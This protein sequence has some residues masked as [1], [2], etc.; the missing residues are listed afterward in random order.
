MG[1]IECVGERLANI[2]INLPR[3]ARQPRLKRIDTLTYAGEPKPVDDPLNPAHFVL[4]ALS[5]RVRDGDCR[6]QIAKRN[7]IPAKRL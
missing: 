4:R 1:E 6:C 2:G 5:A 3:Q 7:M